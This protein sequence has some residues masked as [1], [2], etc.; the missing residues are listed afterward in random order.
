M[1]TGLGAVQILDGLQ[2]GL[3][4]PVLSGVGLAMFGVAW[5]MRPI[6]LGQPMGS[7]R[8]TLKNAQIGPHRVHAALVFSGLACLLVGLVLQYVMS[9]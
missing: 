6:P 1:G 7:I 8:D 4:G 5:F 3:V 2:H 9:V